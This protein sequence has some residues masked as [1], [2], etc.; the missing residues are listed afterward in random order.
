MHKEIF[1]LLLLFIFTFIPCSGV[2][3]GKSDDIEFGKVNENMEDEA[4]DSTLDE[5]ALVGGRAARRRLAEMPPEE[6]KR[7]IR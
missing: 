4:H 2:D 7:E 6:A 5:E 3:S 1:F